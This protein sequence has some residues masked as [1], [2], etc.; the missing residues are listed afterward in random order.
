MSKRI[1][2]YVQSK[3]LTRISNFR[4]NSAENVITIATC[5]TTVSIVSETDH[6]FSFESLLCLTFRQ[7][8]VDFILENFVVVTEQR[9]TDGFFM[10][11]N[12][13]R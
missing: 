9:D 5:S 1:R 4:K 8:D 7:E 3:S 11:A 2:D 10:S 12:R 6:A 13:K